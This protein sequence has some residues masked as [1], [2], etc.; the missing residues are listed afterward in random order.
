M[1]KTFRVANA[2]KVNG[3][4]KSLGSKEKVADGDYL[5]KPKLKKMGLS[6][7]VFEMLITIGA[8][9]MDATGPEESVES[10]E[11]SKP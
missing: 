10:P 2:K 7:A 4:L 3:A 1:P 8:V 6:S 5:E 9:Q 11:I